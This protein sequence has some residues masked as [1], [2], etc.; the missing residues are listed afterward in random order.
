V[1][2]DRPFVGKSMWAIEQSTKSSEQFYCRIALGSS[3][4]DRF[5]FRCRILKRRE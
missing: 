5:C 4:L 2:A 3:N 1:T